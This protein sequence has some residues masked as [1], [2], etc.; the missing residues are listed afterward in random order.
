MAIGTLETVRPAPLTAGNK[1]P[2]P[3][4]I[5]WI[6]KVLSTGMGE[7]ASD[8]LAHRLG[9]L[10]AVALRLTAVNPS[11]RSPVRVSVVGANALPAAE[12]SRVAPSASETA[13]VD[14]DPLALSIVAPPLTDMPLVD[15]IDAP[16]PI[17]RVPACTLVAPV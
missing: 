17:F 6:I 8:F 14:D 11:E 3:T 9:P 7:T 4:P 16:A 15:A 12:V 10:P 2:L 1:V 13:T 5:F